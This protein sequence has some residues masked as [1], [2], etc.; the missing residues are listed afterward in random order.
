[1]TSAVRASGRSVEITHADRV[2]FP[3]AGLTKLDLAN[4]YAA[5]AE[6]MVPHVR[7]RPLALESFPHGIDG[8]RYFLKNVPKHFPAWIA[9]TVVPRR[10]GAP[11]RQ[12]LANDAATLAYLA[13]QNAVTP[14]VWTSRADR[15]DRPDRLIFDLDPSV[16]RF[17]EVRAAV[18]ALGD[19]LRDLGLA[20]YAMVTGSRGV[21]V[22]VPLRRTA[23]YEQVHAFARD[24]AALFA[25]RNPG[26]LT[27]EFH[28]VK[29][30][31]RIYVDVARNAY[32]QH[33]VTPYAVRGLPDAPVATPLQWE[34]LDDRSLRAQRWTMP[35]VRHRL[36]ELGGDPW[37]DIARHSRPLGAARRALGR[38]AP[39]TL[40][41]GTG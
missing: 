22:T 31:D 2:V 39:G 14:H 40:A 8:E 4:Y 35:S 37:A 30:G 28:R 26:R 32:A 25:S 9:T 3:R 10:T 6:A 16:D 12:A 41:A 36:E 24:V 29:R 27:V 21:H 19:L 34:E 23:A 20:P 1:V 17:A 7:G 15:L 18:R 5:V 11:I 33:A 38:V 13:G